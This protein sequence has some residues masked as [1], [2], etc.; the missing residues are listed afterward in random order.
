MYLTGDTNS[1]TGQMKDFVPVDNFLS[2]L[3]EIDEESHAF[4]NKYTILENLSVPLERSSHDNRTNT[5]GMRLIEICRNNNLFLLNGRLFSDRNV[6]AP[7]FR[8]KSV[9]DYAIS[10]AECFE[11][12]SDFGVYRTDSLFSDGH[13]AIY[14]NISV[15]ATNYVNET[16]SKSLKTPKWQ[17]NLSHTFVENI[18]IEQVHI[19]SENLRSSPCNPQTI[20]DVT[21][22]LSQIF[23][24]ASY[25]TFPICILSC[26]GKLF[27]S[28]LNARLTAF[29][30]N[31]NILE[32]N[33]AGFRQGFSCTDHAFTLHSLIEIL[34]KSITN[35]FEKSQM[36]NALLLFHFYMVN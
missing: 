18:D 15:P 29:L 2:D 14:F 36:L 16:S 4:L 6:G 35:S 7:T 19:L 27:T 34:K 11:F 8:D 20:D 33:Q 10:T 13:N 3:Y 9:I 22:Q 30:E 31:N 28:V 1:R 12:V 26:L 5:H 24:N 32:Q 17:S 25:R 23:Q 21:V